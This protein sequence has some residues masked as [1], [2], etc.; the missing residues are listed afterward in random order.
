MINERDFNINYSRTKS[1]YY[2]CFFEPMACVRWPIREN[3]AN[4]ECQREF[5]LLCRPELKA[6]SCIISFMSVISLNP[7]VGRFYAGMNGR[8][9]FFSYS[10]CRI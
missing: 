10:E 4:N 3:H 9:L 2:F 7:A 6:S 8:I 5:F 1:E